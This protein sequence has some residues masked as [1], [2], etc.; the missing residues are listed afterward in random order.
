MINKGVIESD[1][2]PVSPIVVVPKAYGKMRICL[3]DKMANKAI[4][5]ERHQSPT[6]DDIRTALNGAK[7]F[8]KIDLKSGYNQITLHPDSRHL[9]AFSAHLGIFQYCRLVFG[10]NTAAEIFQKVIYN[11]I[12]TLKGVLYMNK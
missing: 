9:T 6:I 1:P 3:D 7:Y 2:G 11:L 8:C 12:R 4:D 5:R 10:I